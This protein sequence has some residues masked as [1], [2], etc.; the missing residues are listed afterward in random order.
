MNN[1][2]KLENCSIKINQTQIVSPNSSDLFRVCR[3]LVHTSMLQD[4]EQAQK[5]EV[6]H[7]LTVARPYVLT[8]SRNQIPLT[9][10]LFTKPIVH[11]FL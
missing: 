9:G 3:N 2:P 7:D 11:N 6:E 1:S 4:V 5:K 8:F 10:S